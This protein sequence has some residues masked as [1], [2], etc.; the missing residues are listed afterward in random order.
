MKFLFA[1]TFMI[2]AERAIPASARRFGGAFF[3]TSPRD[4][5][6]RYGVLSFP[7]TLL[8]GLAAAS[9]LLAP[10]FHADETTEGYAA[11]AFGLLYAISASVDVLRARK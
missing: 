4:F 1:L 9:F 8:G 10:L 11:V 3:E 7:R 2:M 5:Y 6:A